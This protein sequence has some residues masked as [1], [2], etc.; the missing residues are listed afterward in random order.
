MLL[1]Y[2]KI[3]LI[4]LVG[5]WGL[6]GAMGNLT[7]P[8]PELAAAVMSMADVPGEHRRAVKLT[9][10]ALCFAGAFRLWRRRRDRGIEFDRA[11]SWAV[12]GCAAAMAMLYGVFI[13][14]M[15]TFFEGWQTTIGAQATPAAFAYF[16]CIALIAVFVNMRAHD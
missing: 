10:A 12:A 13:V 15:D 6:F 7:R 2:F 14:A 8:N 3:F 1:R 11:K 4:L 16:G 9:A 5:F